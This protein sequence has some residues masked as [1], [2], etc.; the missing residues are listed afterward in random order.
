MTKQTPLEELERMAGACDQATFGLGEKDVLDESYRKAGK[1]DK[2]S[3]SAPFDLSASHIL[4]RVAS[5]LFYG[6]TA[7]R[8]VYAEL[9]K[10]NIYGKE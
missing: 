4:L 8:Y 7:E 3:F 5:S 1:M 2:S 9:Y 10:L 6:K